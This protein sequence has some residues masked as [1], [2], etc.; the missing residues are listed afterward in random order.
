MTV[1]STNRPEHLLLYEPRTEGHHLGWLRFITEDLLSADV[2]LSLAVDLRP[3]AKGKIEGHLSDLLPRVKLLPAHDAA[4]RRHGD[5]K[6][7]SVA[8]CLRQSGADNVFLCALDEIASAC[9]RRATFGFLPPAELRGR[10]GGIYHRPRFFI[11]PW[12]SPNRWLKQ[13]GFRRLVREKWLQQLLFVDE[14]LAADLQRQLP[15]APVFFLPDPCPPGF[16][17][18]A[19]A[20]RQQLG[21]PEDK[22][23]FLFYGVGY[24]RKGLHLAV[25]AMRK[26]PADSPAF[27]LC[28]GQQDPTG[29]TAHGLEELVR[30]HRARLINRYIST[31]EEKACFIA[32][33]VVVLPYLNH[34][35]TSGILSRAMAAGKPVIVSDEQLL[36]R[37]T[38]E[39]GLGLLFPSGN[40]AALGECMQTASRW[41]PDETARFSA[42]ARAYALRYSREAYLGALLRSLGFPV[43]SRG[44]NP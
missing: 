13:T 5:G 29:E 7:G 19:R 8:A 36:G 3:E 27:L 39:H 41:S 31:E 9:W 14:Y 26:L 21:V 20:A 25:Q 30:Q 37:L 32:S 15:G 18:D 17:G 1:S 22:L 43:P 24:R 28:G 40:V 4:G 10:M 38:R 6:A 11:A 12:W 44:Q 42:A 34:F 16:H 23:V 2:R 35:G 33:D